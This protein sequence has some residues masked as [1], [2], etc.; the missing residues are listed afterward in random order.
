MTGATGSDGLQPA[1]QA[2]PARRSLKLGGRI[3]RQI[4]FDSCSVSRFA[5]C[6]E[7]ELVARRVRTL[8]T[9]LVLPL[10]V[11]VEVLAAPNASRRRILLA[12]LKLL[13]PALEG[14][15]HAVQVLT[16]P[17]VAASLADRSHDA[18]RVLHG[19]IRRGSLSPEAQTYVDGFRAPQR[20]RER[21]TNRE[22]FDEFQATFDPSQPV[23]SLAEAV[24]AS[25]RKRALLRLYRDGIIEVASDD[26]R[27]VGRSQVRVLR[28]E[29]HRWWGAGWVY[30]ARAACTASSKGAQRQ[31]PGFNDLGLLPL[32]PSCDAFVTDDSG[33]QQAAIAVREVFE[34]SVPWIGNFEDLR[35]ALLGIRSHAGASKQS[36]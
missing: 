17:S 20:R 3:V 7:R 11:A 13:G 31:L 33:L 27:Q 25:A 14:A 35:S 26:G 28:S 24:R 9:K 5:E 16:D 8:N 32:L 21:A 36:P 15:P 4:C 18:T 30:L 29:A 6:V 22:A 23:Q 10:D 34:T 12:T 2:G 19:L 1:P